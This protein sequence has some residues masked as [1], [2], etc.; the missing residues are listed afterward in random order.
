[1]RRSCLSLF[2]RQ[3]QACS[4][5]V[6]KSRS[7]SNAVSGQHGNIT[8]FSWPGTS[9]GAQATTVCQSH[10]HS[11][12]IQTSSGTRHGAVR[13]YST[14]DASTGTRI[15][16]EDIPTNHWVSSLADGQA[17]HMSVLVELKLPFTADHMIRNPRHSTQQG[18]SVA[19][20]LL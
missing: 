15:T 17:I 11:W 18:D 19:S 20:I 16:N 6:E 5:F 10:H 4:S 1:M 13:L 7:L 3:V 14:D 2:A 8:S 9:L 12:H